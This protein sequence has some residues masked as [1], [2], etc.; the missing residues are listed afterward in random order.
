MKKII[1]IVALLFLVIGINQVF[2]KKKPIIVGDDLCENCHL[3]L[4]D[5]NLLPAQAYATDIHK[6][7][8]ITCADC[9]GG[10]ATTYDMDVAMDRNRGF[11][12]V[13]KPQD[14]MKMCI[15]CHSDEKRMKR[16]G[17]ALPTDQF[18]KLQNSVH[19][20]PSSNNRGYIADCISCH[21]VHNI[22]SPGNPA[23]TVYATKIPALCGNCHSNA[24]YMKMY[25]HKLPID[26]VE[27]YK[28]SL[29]GIQNSKGD[30][31]VAQCA[32]CHGH[33]DIRTA[34]DPK[35]SVYV[36]NIPEVCSKCHSDAKKMSKYN[37]P[38]DQYSKFVTSVHGVALLKKHDMSA[39]SC[40][41]CHGNH[42]AVPPGVESISN[43]CGTCHNLN[44]EMFSKSPH[45]AAFDKEHLP[46]CETCH[47]NHGIMPT[48]DNM[49]GTGSE[50]T[51]IKCH[52]ESDKGKG[53]EYAYEMRRLIDSLKADEK[54]VLS[55]LGQAN[56]L[57]MDVADAM[58]AMKDIRQVLIQTR[59]CIHLANFRVF[60]ET[61]QPGF[62]I[63][64]KAAIEG[65]NAIDDYHF[66]RTGL[67]FAT[68]IVTILAL[69][70]YLK[71][72]KIEKVQK[73]KS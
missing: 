37:L 33:H 40:N 53:N 1:Y 22:A 16:L 58:F 29:H 5:K 44:G 54:N 34:K 42:G 28:T 55:L 9:H 45:K 69:S 6:S 65:K 31:T 61:L 72:K 13:P 24:N 19:G 60:K 12:G 71:I 56:A 70:L 21:G 15:K 7:K 38:T 26:Q 27:K 67:G 11:L 36:S 25:N 59:T 41:S 52:D 32:S 3:T 73:E 4:E 20:Q 14:R 23:S 50:T 43:V 66:R 30:I 18:K 62:E 63:T 48:T 35:S 39:P 57:G 49:I 10:D 47:G 46:E 2:S 68:I 8:N 64:K 51:C 17:S